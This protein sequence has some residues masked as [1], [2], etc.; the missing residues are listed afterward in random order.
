MSGNDS[1]AI[2]DVESAITS[3]HSIRAFLPTPVPRET[4]ERILAIASGSRQPS[5]MPQT[6][7]SFSGAPRNGMIRRW[8][9]VHAACG[10]VSRPRPRAATMTPC[11]NM[12]KSSQLPCPMIRSIVNIMPTGASKKR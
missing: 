6:S 2:L 10:Q 11:R 9:G 7:C 3:R 5:D 8:N 1:P 12:P 4:I